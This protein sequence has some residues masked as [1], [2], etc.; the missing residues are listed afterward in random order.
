M[1]EGGATPPPET[2]FINSKQKDMKDIAEILCFK[3]Y[4]I[5]CYQ[6]NLINVR[7]GMYYN[8]SSRYFDTLKEVQEY[9][10]KNNLDPRYKTPFKRGTMY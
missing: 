8:S 4:G 2:K 9:V 7:T 10:T 3:T 6:V 5:T 1:W